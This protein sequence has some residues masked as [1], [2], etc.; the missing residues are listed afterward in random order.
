MEGASRP[1]LRALACLWLCAV[2]AALL[3]HGASAGEAE[4]QTVVIASIDG[5]RRTFS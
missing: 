1:P 3:P 4:Q 5:D 2:A